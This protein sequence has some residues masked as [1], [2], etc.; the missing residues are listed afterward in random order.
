MTSSILAT[1]DGEADQD[2]GAVAGLVEQEPGA[3]RDHFLAEG[4]EGRQNLT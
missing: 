4:D 2:M 3:A 1:A